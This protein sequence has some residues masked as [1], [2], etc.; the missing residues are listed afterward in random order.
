MSLSTLR[1]RYKVS[2]D[3]AQNLGQ[4][5]LETVLTL[6]WDAYKDLIQDQVYEK[7]WKEVQITEEWFVRIQKRWK[8][9]NISAIPIMEKAD[10]SKASKAKK[11]KKP[12][13]DF[14][15]RSYWD[16]NSY[17]GAEC[18]LLDES[19]FL[20]REYIFEGVCRYLSGKYGS[21]CSSGS[22]V[23][24]V[25]GTDLS[26]VLPKLDIA[27]SRFSE[28]PSLTKK[29]GTHENHY[30]SRHQRSMGLTPFELHHLFFLF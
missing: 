19:N 11:G 2:E 25:Q 9:S 4:G 15:F 8:K 10:S 18:K 24:Y 22:M 12:T 28:S 20:V 27:M 1:Q 17:F 13:I 6:M 14:C 30:N 5:G 23:G 7:S 21:R 3:F 29:D 16:Q 26:K